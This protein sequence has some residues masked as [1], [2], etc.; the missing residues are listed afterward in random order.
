M[1]KNIKII[2]E[3]SEILQKHHECRNLL[4]ELEKKLTLYNIEN[5][6][7]VSESIDKLA[8]PETVGFFKPNSYVKNIYFYKNVEISLHSDEVGEVLVRSLVE[9]LKKIDAFNIYK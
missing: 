5:G 1:E 8:V 4:S 7:D 2:E 6:L 9:E 3:M